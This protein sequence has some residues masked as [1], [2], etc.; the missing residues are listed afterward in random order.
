MQKE[1]GVKPRACLKSVVTNPDSLRHN[2]KYILPFLPGAE[3]HSFDS[4]ALGRPHGAFQIG[5]KVTLL[6]SLIIEG[7]YHVLVIPEG[8]Q[9]K[10]EIPVN[11]IQKPGKYKNAGFDFE[12][13][14][15]AHLNR[16]GL[17]DGTGA[18]CSNGNDF[19]IKHIDGRVFNGE[20]KQNLRAA[21]GQITLHYDGSKGWWIGDKAR[22]K[23]PRYAKC[24]ERATSGGKDLITILNQTYGLLDKTSKRSSINVYSDDTNLTPMSAY[25]EDHDVDLLHLGSHGTM[26]T[27]TMPGNDRIGLGLDSPTGVGYY[28]VR[29]KHPG[30]LTVQF[31]IRSINSSSFDLMSE[32]GTKKIKMRMGYT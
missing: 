23:F 30:T 32:E 24:V 22:A 17:M 19:H 26:S 7:K 5:T 31:K 20:A 13:Y 8:S 9:D 29:N 3:L 11:K 2:Q 15:V 10:H 25:L 1:E 16:H 27:N 18:G 28:R 12:D 4:H 14:V 21:F 6:D